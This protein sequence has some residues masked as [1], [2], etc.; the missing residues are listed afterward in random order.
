MSGQPMPELA[1]RN[2]ARSLRES[3]KWI[4]DRTHDCGSDNHSDNERK[5]SGHPRNPLRFLAGFGG[6][7]YLIFDRTLDGLVSEFSLRL[8]MIDGSR[9]AYR[10]IIRVRI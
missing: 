2:R 6:V 10:K 7:R 3:A 9:Q 5:Q 4:I 8:K 1:L